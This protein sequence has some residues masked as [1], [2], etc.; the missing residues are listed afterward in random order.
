MAAKVKYPETSK[1]LEKLE[2]LLKCNRCLTFMKVPITL[3]NCDHVFCK[4]C[5]DDES[6][7]PVCKTPCW[8]SDQQI[9]NSLS[10]ISSICAQLRSHLTDT[11]QTP[12]IKS[13]S[14]TNK[15]EANL[16]ANCNDEENCKNT[17]PS[18]RTPVRRSITASA[19]KQ[20]ALKSV[21]K[22]TPNPKRCKTELPPMP[23][24]MVKNKKGETKLHLAA[25]Q[26]DLAALRLL[27]GEE[28]TDVNAKDNAG[29]TSLHEACNR[30]YSDIAEALINSGAFVDIPGYENETPLMDAVANNRVETVKLLVQ[31]G[32]NVNLRSLQGKT[33]IT[34]ARNDEI[35]QLLLSVQSETLENYAPISI[36]QNCNFP[37]VISGSSSVSADVLSKAVACLNANLSGEDTSKISHLIVKC[38]QNNRTNRTL[39]YLQAVATGAWVLSDAWLNVCIREN[40]YVSENGYTVD[41]CSEDFVLH[42]PSRS[43]VGKRKCLP[44]LFDGCH[45]YLSGKF[46]PPSLKKEEITEL[47]TLA[48]GEI[49]SREPKPDSDCVQACTKISYHARPTC[50]HYLHTYYIVFDSKNKSQRMVVQGKV[51]T[52]TETWILYCI[53]QFSI[54][55]S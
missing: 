42:G 4:K 38:D 36:S 9:N 53:S 3:W 5:L 43:N 11:N 14:I 35:K 44:R 25:I 20:W 8:A 49:L 45:F 19:T 27:L 10:V 1:A 24:S 46:T 33:A 51:A 47:I 31:K 37:M 48:G 7:C 40:G 22:K 29:W 15:V 28:G 52:V 32:A 16:K 6:C 41:G 18:K 2:N 23:R 54:L 21:E 12:R 50:T 55:S 34:L 13:G 17:L 30:G 26:R 39:K